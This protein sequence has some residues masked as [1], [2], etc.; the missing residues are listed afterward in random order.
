MERVRLQTGGNVRVVDQIITY[1][2]EQG[3]LSAHD[4]E[5]LVAIGFIKDTQTED[6]QPADGRWT[7]RHWGAVDGWIVYEE[8]ES[9]QTSFETDETEEATEAS[10][11]GRRTRA[12]GAARNGRGIGR[13]ATVAGP[14]VARALSETPHPRPLSRARERG[15][16]ES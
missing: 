2:R 12:P 3:I 16:R 14:R 15:G 11:S 13:G 8:G 9:N 1:A 5:R 6:K 7:E 4:L 10:K